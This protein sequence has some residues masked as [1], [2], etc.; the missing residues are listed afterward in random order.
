[1]DILDKDFKSIVLNMLRE[2]KEI[3]R[4]MSEQI[5][6]INKDG[7]IIKRSQIEIPELRNTIIGSGSREKRISKVD[8]SQ[9]RLSI[10]GSRKRKK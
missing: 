2:L 9:T 7:E 6:N 8:N 10:L 3:R 1:M 5:G 4:V